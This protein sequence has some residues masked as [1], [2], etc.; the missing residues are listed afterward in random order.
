MLGCSVQVQYCKPSQ[1]DS[2]KNN[3]TSLDSRKSAF[4]QATILFGSNQQSQQGAAFNLFVET[5]KYFGDITETFLSLGIS[6]LRARDTLTLGMQMPLPSNQ[7][8]L[9][10]Q[11]WHHTS[12][13][14]LQR[15]L[16]EMATGPF[17]TAMD[18]M[19]FIANTSTERKVCQNMVRGLRRRYNRCSILL[20]CSRKLEARPRLPLAFL[21]CL[22]LC[23]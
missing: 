8:E 7:W 3:C 15:T 12:L 5:V 22:S 1:T 14:A 10:V 9:E 11:G 4:D 13:A 17:D 6:A 20:T 21:V 16:L 23:L 18:A 19:W 2:S